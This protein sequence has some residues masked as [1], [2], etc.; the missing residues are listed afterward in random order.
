MRP[1][2]TNRLE[3]CVAFVRERVGSHWIV[4]A[5]LALGKPNHLVNAL[6]RAARADPSIRLE[7]FTALSLNPPKPAAGLRQRFLG[8]F[9]ARQFGDYP[10]LEY[11]QDL[12]RKRVP[13]NITISEF[14]FR[15]GTRLGDAHAQ[16]HYV[17]SNYTHVA[18]D[19]AARRVNL[20]VQMVGV[21][22]D[23]PGRYS[24]SCNPD[25]SL[26]L[27][28]IVPRD[29]LTLLGQLN[30]ELPYMDGDAE[31]P[32]DTFDLVLDGHPQRLFAVPRMPVSDADYLIGLHTS[33]LIHDGGT[34]QIGIGSLGDAVSCFTV[35]RH[36]D[37][38][39]YRE[40][41]HDSEADQRVGIPLR[42]AWGGREPFRSG[43]YA[44]SEMFTEGFLHLYRAGVLSRKVYDHEGLQKLLNRGLI[45]ESLRP[46]A[47][48]VL[49]D[50]GLLKAQLDLQDLSWL[51]QFGFIRE[52]VRCDAGTI[53]IP[54]HAPLAND[55][56][57]PAV[58][59]DLARHAGG[60]SLRNGALLH[61]AFFLGSDWMYDTLRSMPDEE[62]A[63]FRMTAVSRINQLYQGE[64]L[65]RAQRLEG[66]FINSTMKITLLGAAVS[67]QLDGGQV[68]SGVGGQ[69]NFV[70]MAHALDRSRSVLMLRSHRGAGADAR[71]NIVWEFPHAT[72]PRHLRDL[73]VTEYGVADLR[74]SSDEEVVR[75][76]ICIADN[77]W[78][79]SLR[80]AAVRAGKLS[81][82]WRV[83]EPWCRNSPEWAH[84]VIEPW[85]AR[86]VIREYPFGSD[87]TPE[88]E[89]LA[90]ALSY[91]Q[92]NSRR[93][94]QRVG[95]LLAALGPHGSTAETATPALR[96]MGLEAVRNAHD[97]LD[98]RL[99]RLALRSTTMAPAPP[100][101]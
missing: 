44:A 91:L 61:A 68:V 42:D 58:R 54:G 67:D 89:L 51:Q 50:Q 94:P 79:E 12:D 99:L 62:R 81:A 55:L 87:F 60:Q 5:P 38:A 77:R 53:S 84:R 82:D 45:Q 2:T 25:V 8:P 93:L 83:P 6:Y 34:L 76:L 65:D 20:L 17:S 24:L 100:E 37:N 66:R 36:R 90:R 27:L 15:S 46:D 40:I 73:V 47:L 69:Y 16:R 35:M 11:L 22:A 21:R 71:S 57:Q 48:E 41:L 85:R 63:Q 96:R 75:A 74:S 92:A 72:I 78:Q 70:A 52:G 95:L 4:G 18:R 13:D 29:Q 43:L 30:A 3:D 28:R 14:Y 97:W 86:G 39:R 64:A 98:R 23:R 19:M 56:R 33:Q 88:E 59:A 26:D 7:L 80:L 9:V 49:W 1:R 101:A 32:A 31:V 10:R